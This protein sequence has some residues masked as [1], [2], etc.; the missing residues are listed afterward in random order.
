MKLLRVLQSRSFHRLGDSE[1]RSF[2]GKV[3]AATHRDL[4]REMAIGRFREDLYYRLCSDVVYTPSL[5]E[6][7]AGNVEELAHL[8]G[9]LLQRNLGADDPRTFDEV[10]AGIEASV[11]LDYTWPGNMRELDQCVRN[12]LIHGGYAPPSAPGDR[13]GLEPLFEDMR[14]ATADLERV[15]SGYTRWVYEQD[16][17]YTGAGETLGIDRRTVAK[18]VAD[19]SAGDH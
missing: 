19:G 16:G 4:A 5:R 12:L 7:I 14:S 3:V 17:S 6:Q 15:V 18:H 1:P 2:G 11:G 10:M 8:V 13:E 9:V